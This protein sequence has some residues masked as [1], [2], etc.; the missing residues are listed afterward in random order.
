FASGLLG[1]TPA[2]ELWAALADGLT[3]ALPVLVNTDEL[4]QRL[5][6]LS[7]SPNPA[8]YEVML[9]FSLTEPEAL[10]YA[11]RDLTG[12]LVMEGDLG[13]VPAGDFAQRLDV[14]QLVAGMYTLELRSDTGL[15]SLKVVVAD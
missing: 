8:V 3:F 10:R 4:D 1:G 6:D 5:S 9:R 11:L 14:S 7:I 12:R 2:F 13:L 15:R